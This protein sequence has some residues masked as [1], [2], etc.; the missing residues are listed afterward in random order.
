[1]TAFGRA[2][3][4]KKMI[5]Q[6]LM[7]LLRDRGSGRGD[8]TVNDD[9]DLEGGATDVRAGHRGDLETAERRQYRF[10]RRERVAMNLERARDHLDFA[11]DAGVVEAGATPHYRAWLYRGQR[12]ENRG[13]GR[14]VRDAHLADA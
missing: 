11:P 13:G 10:A 7:N 14:A 1:M 6:S 2:M 3:A 9:R 5:E 4:E 12:A 8:K